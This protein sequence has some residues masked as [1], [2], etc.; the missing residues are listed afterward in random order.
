MTYIADSATVIGQVV[1]SRDSSVWSQAVLRGE[2][3]LIG[4]G[5]NVQG[6]GRTAQ[7]SRLFLVLRSS[8][9]TGTAPALTVK[10]R[11]ANVSFYGDLF[12]KSFDQHLDERRFMVAPSCC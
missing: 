2:P 3:I 12:V 7:R 5:S 4:E 9:L 1:L 10:A 6:G 8:V 11:A